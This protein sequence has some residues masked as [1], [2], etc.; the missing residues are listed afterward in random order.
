[1]LVEQPREL[2]EVDTLSA[3]L[4]R[5][6]EDFAHLLLGDSPLLANVARDALPL[7]G[8]EDVVRVRDLQQERTRRDRDRVECARAAVSIAPRSKESAQR[9]ESHGPSL[10][11][12]SVF[13]TGDS[14]T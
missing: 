7:L 5:G 14:K 12:D 6:A 4:L 9:I 2:I 8:S 11:R 13:G 3:L 1:M 10:M